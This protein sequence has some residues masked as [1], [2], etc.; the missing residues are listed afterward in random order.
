MNSLW[1]ALRF[2]TILPLPEPKEIPAD[3]L[4]KSMRFFPLAG[5]LIGFTSWGFYLAA[6]KFLPGP[7]PALVLL[8]GPIFLSGGLHLDGFADFCD[9]FFSGKDRGG[10]LRIMKDPHLGTWGVLGLALLLISKWEVLKVLGARPAVFILA[11]TVARWTQVLL[12]W[13]FSYAR[14]EGGLGGAVAKKAG[15]LELGGATLFV[16]P[17]V[18]WVGLDSIA[19]L[20]VFIFFLC[21]FCFFIFKKLGGVT[22]DVLGAASELSEWIILIAAVCLPGLKSL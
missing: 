5:G 1:T 7:L 22:G 12:S 15:A 8:M 14:P 6:Q 4:A 10:I 2:L 21:G 11:L 3:G 17:A 20:A 9:G 16:L 18:F 13:A 19:I